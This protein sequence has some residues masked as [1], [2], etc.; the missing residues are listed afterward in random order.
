MSAERL[1]EAA[2]VLRE[3]AG[4]ATPGPWSFGGAGVADA[5]GRIPIAITSPDH[6]AYGDGGWST[7]PDFMAGIRQNAGNGTW[8]ATMHPGVGLALA[9]LLGATARAARLAGVAAK[10]PEALSIRG[11][12]LAVADAI[13]GGAS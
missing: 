8:V 4:A 6:F 7:K 5:E 13:L 10:H 12:A 9:D 11:K 1:R 2:K 3:R